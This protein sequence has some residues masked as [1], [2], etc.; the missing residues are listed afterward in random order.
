MSSRELIGRRR[1]F[2]WV[3]LMS[4]DAETER[5]DETLA[6]PTLADWQSGP[7]ATDLAP[8]ETRVWVVD[9]D[10]GSNFDDDEDAAE[11]GSDREILSADEQARADR[12]VRA[13]DRRRFVRCRA[14]VR[15]ILGQ[16]ASI[17]ANSVIF[18]A[19]GHG[20]PELDWKAMGA[21][22][23]GSRFAPPI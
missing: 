6:P 9:L 22:D 19:A 1:S 4:T 2:E 14:A 20:K 23:S 10:A 21:E 16:V 8:G 18:R 3:N 11:P 15:E 7:I 12:F 5:D 17:S 13:R